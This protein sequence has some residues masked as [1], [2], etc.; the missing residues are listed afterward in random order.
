MPDSTS[1]FWFPSPSLILLSSLRMASNKPSQLCAT[2]RS[3]I[4]IAMMTSS[5]H[6]HYLDIELE[7]DVENGKK[8]IRSWY[9]IKLS[10]AD[11]VVAKS[12][13]PQPRFLLKWKWNTGHEMWVLVS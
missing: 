12:A 10:V 9:S 4:A 11:K 3:K 5:S 1:S 7:G 8:R 6:D 2:L 13:H